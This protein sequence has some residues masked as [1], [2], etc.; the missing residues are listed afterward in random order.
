MSLNKEVL[1][2]IVESLYE[3]AEKYE[4]SLGQLKDETV[5]SLETSLVELATKTVPQY[6]NKLREEV[7]MLALGDMEN[8]YENDTTDE[9]GMP[10]ATDGLEMDAMHSLELELESAREELAKAKELIKELLAGREPKPRRVVKTTV[11]PA[12]ALCARMGISEKVSKLW[13]KVVVTQDGNRFGVSFP[14]NFYTEEKDACFG[15]LNRM[16]LRAQHRRV[17]DTHFTKAGAL[18]IVVAAPQNRRREH[19]I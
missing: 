12:D 13:E 6:I 16:Y 9:H 4:E 8:D 3:C 5:S 10:T 14:P 18:I 7:S 1:V 2:S 11:S 17:I 19:S 15:F